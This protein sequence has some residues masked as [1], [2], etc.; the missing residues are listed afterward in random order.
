MA[1]AFAARL[2]KEAPTARQQIT[3]AFELTYSR[4]PTPKELQLSLSH[5]N[6]MKAHHELHPPPP[7]EAAK[8]IVHAITSELTG[9][10]FTFTQ[11]PPP[12]KYEANLH[13][14]QV[15]ANT[16]ALAD[17]TLALINSNEFLYVY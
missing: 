5:L 17:L 2:S 7:I 11:S 13:P 9:E 12:T 10:V 8:P 14:S 3:R 6:R 1:L 4:P 16:R 15:N